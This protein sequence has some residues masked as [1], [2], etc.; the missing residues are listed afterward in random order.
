MTE[1]TN[2]RVELSA[3]ARR[4][5][6]GLPKEVVIRLLNAVKNLSLTPRPRGCIKLEG[7][8]NEYRVRVGDYRI[9]YS[10]WDDKLVILVIDLGHRKDIYR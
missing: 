9:I 1:G 5:L 4:A 3:T 10:V 7:T 6:K 2:Y 8:E